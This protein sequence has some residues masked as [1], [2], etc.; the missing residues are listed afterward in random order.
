MA[1]ENDKFK[2]KTAKILI[3]EGEKDVARSLLETSRHPKAL[4]ML[5]QLP[6][7]KATGSPKPTNMMTQQ[8]ILILI[9][10]VIA[11]G[12]LGFMGGR[13][14]APVSTLEEVLNQPLPPGPASTASA[15]ATRLQTTQDS[16]KAT[17]E[18]VYTLLTATAEAGG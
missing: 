9:G 8:L 4:S 2:V 10:G 13:L 18:H 1:I 14:T 3:R 5:S 15:Q 6:Q 11:G 17:N 12:I 7:G 16:V